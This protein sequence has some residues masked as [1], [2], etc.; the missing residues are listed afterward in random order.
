MTLDDAPSHRLHDAAVCVQ[1]GYLENN[2]VNWHVNAGSS[3][4]PRGPPG[5]ATWYT[6]RAEVRSS[7]VSVF[8]DDVPVGEGTLHFP[9]RGRGG[10]LALNKLQNKVYFRAVRITP[11]V[12]QY[13]ESHDAPAGDA[14]HVTCS[15]AR[16]QTLEC[17]SEKKIKKV[18]KRYKNY[19]R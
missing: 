1:F 17:K 12:A 9:P 13:G 18:L 14:R 5:G 15:Y 8:L 10:V 7:G 11:A 2:L 16:R 19:Y 3:R 4:C 6:I